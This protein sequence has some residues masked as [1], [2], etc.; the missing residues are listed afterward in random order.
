MDVLEKEPKKE[1]TIL[2]PLHKSGNIRELLKAGKNSN[3]NFDIS[4]LSGKGFSNLLEKAK[5]L[6]TKEDKN[7]LDTKKEELDAII[8]KGKDSIKKNK[9]SL[10]TIPDNFE[11]LRKFSLRLTNKKPNNKI[12]NIL[13]N[14][15][16]QNSLKED[17]YYNLDFYLSLFCNANNKIIELLSY[18][19]LNKK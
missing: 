4:L 2:N 9:I 19:N 14:T 17:N 13:T 16:T 12:N 7:I 11:I 5:K 1:E 15:D 8:K 18:F 3:I 10:S 6:K